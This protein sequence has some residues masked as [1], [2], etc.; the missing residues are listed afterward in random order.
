MATP[1]TAIS[2]YAGVL[3][4]VMCVLLMFAFVIGDPLMQYAGAPGGGATGG[5]AT[6]VSWR[7]GDMNERQMALAVRH[8]GVLAEFQRAV[9]TLG[10]QA[11]EEAGVDDLGLR[12]QPIAL[13]RTTEEGV[14]QDIVVNKLLAKRARDAGMVVTDEMIVDYFRALG[15]DRVGNEQMRQILSQLKQPGG[16]SATIQ[17]VFDLMREAMLAQRYLASY[18]YA[19]QTILPQERWE[20]WRKLN[21]RVSVEA[22]PLAVERF[23][24]QVEE[25]S[26]EELL[27]FFQLYRNNLPSPVR[28]AG[29]EL[30]SPT[31][32]FAVPRRVKLSYL[33]ADF[34]TALESAMDEVTDEQVAQ[35]Y[36]ENKDQFVAADRA[37]FGD[38]SLFGPAEGEGNLP[39]GEE[40]PG[41][42]PDA[43]SPGPTAPEPDAPMDPAPA[44]AAGEPDADQPATEEGAPTPEDA[45]GDS[46]ADEPASDPSASPGEES[47]QEPASE[48]PEPESSET[49]ETPAADSDDADDTAGEPVEEEEEEDEAPDSTDDEPTSDEQPSDPTTEEGA[50]DTPYQP[51]EEVSDEIRRA[52]ATEIASRKLEE[53][54]SEARNRLDDAFYKYLDK[55]IVADEDPEAEAPEPPAILTDLRPL[56]EE[57]QLELKETDQASMLDLRDTEVGGTFEANVPPAAA[58]PLF[59]LAFSPQEA[60]LYKPL[61]TVALSGDRYLTLV[62]E[63][64]PSETPELDEVREQVVAAWKR[65]KAADLALEAAE[66]LAERATESGKPLTEYLSGA[67]E[68]YGLE[69]DD[70]VET[71]AFSL[72]QFGPMGPASQQPTLEL[73]QPAPLVAAGPELLQAAFDLEAG[74]AT[75]EL[76]YDRSIAYVL[77]VAQKIGTED[78][79]RREFLRAGSNWL[80]RRPLYSQRAARVRAALVSDLQSEM[81]MQWERTP[82]EAL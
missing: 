1:L 63:R 43:E 2:K 37:L 40:Q 55:K 4:A 60:E 76:N 49:P 73:S 24:D 68:T 26:E 66:K 30:P 5:G 59:V 34:A 80:G 38:E 67:D 52:L 54:I 77:R 27:E 36:E 17:F 32:G 51:L 48:T 50:S 31:P 74:E 57:H 25:P 75:A 20:D 72:L 53:R 44:D 29:V 22:A 65:Q 79:L 21:E 8:R 39:F 15:R 70:V 28:V 18:T 58:R 56:A 82:D 16:R 6:V 41:D 3:M 12:I 33:R 81:D 71:P 61:T 11:A 45:A 35:Y 47:P 23:A 62:T 64:Y 19:L 42:T 78:E 7:G 14:E 69:A 46:P 10:L 9:Y 13:P